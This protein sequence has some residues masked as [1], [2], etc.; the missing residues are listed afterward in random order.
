[1][2]CALADYTPLAALLATSRHPDNVGVSG[3]MTIT[4]ASAL[5][6]QAEF[7]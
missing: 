2:A 6:C 7:A 3:E 1:M 5:L 4:L